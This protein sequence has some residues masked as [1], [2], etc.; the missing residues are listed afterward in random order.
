LNRIEAD[1]PHEERFI[2]LGLD[3][4]SRLLVV[5]YTYHREVIRLISARKAT[6][7]EHRYYEDSKYG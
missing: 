1:Y 3:L 2:T 5:V 6:L 4:Q 7:R